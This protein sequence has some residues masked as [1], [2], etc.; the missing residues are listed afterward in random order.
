MVMKTVLVTGATDGIG[1]E[2]ASQLLAVGCTVLVHGRSQSKAEEAVVRLQGRHASAL[3]LP[4]AGDF[5]S[6]EGV[7]RCADHIRRHVV[8]GSLTVVHNAAAFFASF[9]RN[10]DGIERS[11]MVNH[12]APFFLT[13]LLMQR[14][15][16]PIERVVMVSALGHMKATMP[17]DVNDAGQFD[18]QQRYMQC[19]LANV[20]FAAALHRIYNGAIA[21]SSIHP[22]VVTTKLLRAAYGMDGRDDVAAAAKGIAWLAHHEDA[23]SPSGAFFV[24]GKPAAANPLALD[25]GVQDQLWEWSEQLC[26]L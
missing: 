15:A 25:V 11:W 4:V 16:T 23:A 6:L 5:E 7:G 3:L 1:F 14:Q 10:V 20:A 12:I 19:K 24:R 22:G 17:A 2:T 26:G 8:E 21:A 9:E 13:H 18:P